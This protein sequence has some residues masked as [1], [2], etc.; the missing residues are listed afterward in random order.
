[1]SVSDAQLRL[2]M[3]HVEDAAR[4][5]SSALKKQS[6]A[7]AKAAKLRTEAQR[8]KS[9]S[10]KRTKLSQADREEQSAL[11]AQKEHLRYEGD[12]NK[13]S[14]E[15]EKLRTK[16]QQETD[17]RQAK[18]LEDLKRKNYELQKQFVVTGTTF[19]MASI[20]FSPKQYDFFISHASEDKD[21]IARPLKDSLERLGATVWFDELNIKVGQSIRREIEKG[22]STCSFGVV[23][24]SENFF[25]KNW[26]QM[27]LDALFARKVESGRDLILPIWHKVTKDQVTAAS[28]FLAGV[29]ALNSSVMTV[30]EIAHELHLLID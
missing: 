7:S 19:E 30:D 12:H 13:F 29:L 8:T 26:T 25:R 1:M 2:A 24:L 22:L 14:M 21:D 18:I 27:E 23:I 16:R 20:Q 6:D 15:L 3:K 10:I 17:K 4:K 11:R 28:P 9:E 5:R